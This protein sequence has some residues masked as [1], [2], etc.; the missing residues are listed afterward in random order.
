MPAHDVANSR[1]Q[2]GRRSR[3]DG[4]ADRHELV[5]VLEQPGLLPAQGDRVNRGFGERAAAAQPQ[6]RPGVTETAAKARRPVPVGDADRAEQAV[7]V[8]MQQRAGAGV[9]RRGER[10]PPERW[11]EVVGVDDSHAAPAH[12]PADLSRVEPAGQQTDRRPGPSEPLAR[13]LEQLDLVA[14]PGQ[15]LDEI[16]H[17]AL[18]P[19]GRAVAVVEDEDHPRCRIQPDVDAR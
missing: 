12:E 11:M 13:A 16:A 4:S 17:R 2:R 6:A 8:Q 19:A 9:S 5:D 7:V 3:D 18:L 10:P 1:R 15:Q 14:A